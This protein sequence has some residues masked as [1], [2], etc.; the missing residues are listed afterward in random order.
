MWLE[1]RLE[2]WFGG[3]KARLEA[4]KSQVQGS[5]RPM[6]GPLK[7]RRLSGAT[8]S[9]QGAHWADPPQLNQN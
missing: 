2:R 7:D 4:K 8:V 9:F 1:A 5:E 3:V 6:T